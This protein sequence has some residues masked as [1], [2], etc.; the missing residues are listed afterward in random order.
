VSA[1]TGPDVHGESSNVPAKVCGAL[2]T[3][4]VAD[5]TGSNAPKPH[6]PALSS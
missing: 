1:P 3:H 4:V 2:V 6:E 5:S